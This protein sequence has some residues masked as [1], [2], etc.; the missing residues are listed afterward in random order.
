MDELEHLGITANGDKITDFEQLK[1]N[2][3]AAVEKRTLELRVD[4]TVSIHV[5]RNQAEFEMKEKC[6]VFIWD[7][8]NR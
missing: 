7:M 4:R 1:K 8:I 3:K 2:W 5:A 6:Y